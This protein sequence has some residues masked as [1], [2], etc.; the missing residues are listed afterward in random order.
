MSSYLGNTKATSLSVGYGGP[1][2]ESYNEAKLTVN[3][4]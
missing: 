4:G 3:G 1:T 2:W